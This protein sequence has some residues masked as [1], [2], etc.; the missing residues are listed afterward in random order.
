[1]QIS[2]LKHQHFKIQAAHPYLKKVECLPHDPECF[3]LHWHKSNETN[4]LNQGEQMSW[5]LMSQKKYK[6]PEKVL[7]AE[8]H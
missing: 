8:L 7:F 1:M 3:Y 6:I 5:K 2:V 4:K